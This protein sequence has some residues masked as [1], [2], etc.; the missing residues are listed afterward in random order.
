MS[1]TAALIATAE[2]WIYKK[3]HEGELKG[4]V[5]LSLG[6][7]LVDTAIIQACDNP[8]VFGNHRSHG[9]FIATTGD[10]AGLFRQLL[11]G[12]SQHLYY[13]DK[14]MSTGIQGGLVPVAF[15]NALAF[16]RKGIDRR[17]LCFI[18]DGTMA[19][20]VVWETLQLMQIH[21]V[22][23]TLVVI[24]NNY[25]M[26]QTVRPL[27]MPD[28]PFVAYY[29][30]VGPYDTEIVNAPGPRLL[31]CHIERLC[32]HSCND[33]EM[34]RPKE[35]RDA[36]RRGKLSVLNQVTPEVRDKLQRQVEEAWNAVIQERDQQNAQ[37]VND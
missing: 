1:D 19:Q 10:L 21:D 3:F 25:S 34:Y 18:G 36:V 6:Q 8:L 13:P 27:V 9:Q 30:G 33:T 37:A 32:G 12:Q 22:N 24:D 17:V 20:G 11:A 2:N 7:E 31:Q 26:G 5:H 28:H 23:M 15:G 29:R 35:E 14:F 4:T 16:K